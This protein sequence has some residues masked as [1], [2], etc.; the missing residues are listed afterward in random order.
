[1]FTS[2]GTGSLRDCWTAGLDKY[3]VMGERGETSTLRVS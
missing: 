2:S 3:V 1:M